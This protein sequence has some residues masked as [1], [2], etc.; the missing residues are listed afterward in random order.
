MNF[1]D[2][3]QTW[4]SAHNQPPP[5]DLEKEKMKFF[6]DLRRRRRGAVIFML[7]ILAV[8]T[9]VTVRLGF[10][11]L[12]PD[13]AKPPINLANEWAVFVLLALP[14]MCLLIFFRKY[15]RHCAAHTDY[16][17]SIS[18]TLRGLLDENRMTRERQKWVAILN[19]VTLL[20]IPVIVYQLRAA[21]KAGDEILVP[22]F[23]ML[24]LLMGAIYL[25]MLWH[26]R[27]VLAPRQREL[28][29]L[30]AAYGEDDGAA[31]AR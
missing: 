9:I 13:P 20:L 2:I 17:R 28:E 30:L 16:D 31:A 10:F 7:W 23:V 29:A 6:T 8:L 21:G 5:A 27:R 24:P 14:W 1:D 11:V 19:G 4:G 22:A 26:Q 3:R 12:S 18:V 15:R 25:G